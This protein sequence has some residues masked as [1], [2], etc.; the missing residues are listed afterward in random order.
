MTTNDAVAI[1]LGEAER[2]ARWQS[3]LFWGSVGIEAVLIA[4]F[5]GLADWR[6]RSHVLLFLSTLGVFYAIALGV[7]SLTLRLDDCTRRILT[8]V[9]LL[10]RERSR[11]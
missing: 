6:N 1:A 7:A 9:S 10:A 3:W 2:R 8:A 5:I 4:G 11:S